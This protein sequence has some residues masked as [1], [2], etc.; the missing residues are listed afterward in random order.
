MITHSRCPETALGALLLLSTD[1]HAH[2]RSPHGFIIQR[3]QANLP[4]HPLALQYGDI[5]G[6]GLR[7]VP[8]CGGCFG[9]EVGLVLRSRS[10]LPGWVGVSLMSTH[11]LLR[12]NSVQGL[13]FIYQVHLQLLIPSLSVYYR[14][15]RFICPR[16][17][18][19]LNE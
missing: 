5:F 19:M 4:L 9:S 12:P 15:T 7:S 13:V 1:L 17:P 14:C 8:G 2:C 16:I 3:R 10:G 11:C 18:T 6:T